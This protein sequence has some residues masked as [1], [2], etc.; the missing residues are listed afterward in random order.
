MH[1]QVNANL[2]NGK[3]RNEI[4]ESVKRK[5]VEEIQNSSVELSFSHLNDT[6]HSAKEVAL[7]EV[8]S[9]MASDLGIFCSKIW[10]FQLT[11]KY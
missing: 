8:T 9:Q 6:L 3:I 10:N 2:Y 5:I 4:F 7:Q 1:L 11:T